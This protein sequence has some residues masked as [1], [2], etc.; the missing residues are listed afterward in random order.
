MAVGTAGNVTGVDISNAS[1]KIAR[2]KARKRG[3]L[4]IKF[5]HH[6]VMYLDSISCFRKGSFDVICMCSA[7]CHMLPKEKILN[8]L[9][10]WKT[11]LKPKGR[12]VFDVEVGFHGLFVLP[13][14][15]ILDDI[16]QKSGCSHPAPTTVSGILGR[17]NRA[18]RRC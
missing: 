13:Q 14:I 15:H 10:S 12:I 3:W 11:F 6:N 2:E 18:F 8:V 1:L 9:R 5:I 17:D 16:K 4:A 7:F